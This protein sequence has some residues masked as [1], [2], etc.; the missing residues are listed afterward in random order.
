MCQIDQREGTE[1][2]A[3]IRRVLLELFAKKTW[4]SVQPPTSASVKLR[5]SLIGTFPLLRLEI[6]PFEEARGLS[7]F[8]DLLLEV[9]EQYDAMCG[10]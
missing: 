10:R 8:L 4:R 5:G 7:P 6:M 2:F 9:S 3:A 1:S